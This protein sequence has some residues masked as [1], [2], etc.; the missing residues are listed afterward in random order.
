MAVS[1]NKINKI[2]FLGAG[3]MAE[4]LISGLISSGVARA[5]NIAAADICVPRL[6]LLKKKYG[7]RTVSDNRLLVGESDIVFL[8]VKPKDVEKLLSETGASFTP[9]KLIASIAA[10][11]T[12]AFIE[13]FVPKN[14]AVVRSMPNTPALLGKG[15]IAISAGRY[16][17]AG[18]LKLA[19]KALSAAGLV[20]RLEEKMINAVTAVSGS[21][22]AYVFYIA[23]ALENAAVEIGL[24]R[25]TAAL[26]ARQTI[27]GAGAMLVQTQDGPD[28]LRKKV[29][30]PGGTTEAAV[31]FL[32]K[33]RFA[34]VFKQAVRKAFEKAGQLSGQRR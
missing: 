2:G 5:G 7:V 10:G 34:D 29:T 9:S 14:V 30:S 27:Y 11:I 28:V 26:L 19:H 15:A 6:M 13:K 18:H 12:S 3:N 16:A 32:E 20:V 21:G 22:P 33:K 31:M 24:D 25:A 8:A 23:E 4:A 17:R 1:G